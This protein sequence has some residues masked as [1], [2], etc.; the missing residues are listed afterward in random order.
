[1]CVWKKSIFGRMLVLVVAA[2][3]GEHVGESDCWAEIDYCG[4]IA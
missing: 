3:G 2:L 4:G 1:M